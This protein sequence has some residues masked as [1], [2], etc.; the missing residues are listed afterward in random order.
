MLVSTFKGCIAFLVFMFNFF[1]SIAVLVIYSAQTFFN[2][3]VVMFNHSQVSLGPLVPAIE[4]ENKKKEKKKEET[5]W[6]SYSN[7]SMIMNG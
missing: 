6:F 4:S 7:L 1:F 3:L 2:L 5:N